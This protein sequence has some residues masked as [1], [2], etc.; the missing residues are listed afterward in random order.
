LKKYT[1]LAATILIILILA[2]C[3]GVNQCL[4]DGTTETATRQKMHHEHQN[5]LTDPE[6]KDFGTDSTDVA[7]LEVMANDIPIRR[8]EE[9]SEDFS[10]GK[11][12]KFSD[13][14]DKNERDT[15]NRSSRRR[16]LDCALELCQ[17]AQEYW[18]TGELDS[19][20]E[21]LDEAYQL[22]LK[23]NTY[24][25]PKLIQQ[26]DDLRFMISKRIL[27]IYASRNI[28]VEGNHKAI[29]LIINPHVQSEINLFTKGREKKFFIESYK[30]SGLYRPM[31]VEELRKAGLPTELS[32][33]PL[34]ESGFKVNALSKARALG[35]WQFI[36]STGYKFGLKR[37][38]YID[39]RLDFQKSTMAAIAYLKELHQ[40][41]GDWTTVLAGYNCGE[42]RVLRVIRS[43]NV[44]Y[45]DNFW[46]LYERL[47]RETARYVPRFLATLHIVQN[48][49]K[50]GLAS[51]EPF[52]PIEF[53]TVTISRKLHL[54]AISNFTGISEKTLKSL[55]PELRYNILPSEDY[56]LRM[57]N[58]KT[59]LLLSKLESIPEYSPPQPSYV[60]HRVRRG[61][62]ISMIARKYGSNS[63]TIA[64]ANHLNR[65]CL[66]QAGQTL[67]IP[68]KG[69]SAFISKTTHYHNTSQGRTF[70]HRVKA[71]DS[72][73]VLAR[74]YG[75]TVKSIQRL[76]RLS[77]TKLYIGQKLKISGSHRMASYKV[78][79]GDSPF[80]IA[81]R[82]NMPLDKFMKL[83]HLNHHS[84]IYP[85]ENYYVE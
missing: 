76:N 18:Q 81:R 14:P 45:L 54:A 66:I 29:P 50:Y 17:T 6:I 58:G 7:R 84:K 77:T 67:K 42:G 61:E 13:A 57:P 9:T 46:D 24:D 23:V 80:S 5:Q 11:D 56:S 26:K 73:W 83:N 33:L 85:G 39:E 38:K 72:L 74:K 48:L 59:N 22:I 52:S 37:N 31:I 69:S 1:F 64:R 2:G 12:D 71:G 70:T 30:R 44:N 27:E 82:H 28:V 47:P 55:N 34:I 43:Q 10:F 51:V 65:R 16:S 41:F 68:L 79:R 32:W 20:L 78:K 75:T 53:E 4:T 36:P 40:I 8:Q 15:T 62:N 49:E 63:R 3:S 60:Y 21:A 19:A 25:K 35:L